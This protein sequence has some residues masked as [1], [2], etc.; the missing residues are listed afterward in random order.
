MTRKR[1]LESGHIGQRHSLAR[2]PP[3]QRFIIERMIAVIDAANAEDVEGLP[4]IGCRSFLAGVRGEK[5]TFIASAPEHPGKL[6]RRIA[7]LG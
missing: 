1:R 5:E 6:A 7:E 2:Q 3:D 4:D